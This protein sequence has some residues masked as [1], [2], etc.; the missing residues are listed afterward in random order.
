M[1]PPEEI[2][3]EP[4]MDPMIAAEPAPGSMDFFAPEDPQEAVLPDVLPERIPEAIDYNLKLSEEEAHQLG[5]RVKEEV[6][7]WEAS[8]EQRR[9]N[10]RIWE[11]DFE[12]LEADHEG[13]WENSAAVRAPFTAWA[14]GSHS[15]R[16]NGAIISPKPA[17]S[18]VAKQ[19]AALEAAPVIEEVMQA[20]LEESGWPAFANDMHIELPK[21]GMGLGGVEWEI[22][23]RRQP[24]PHFDGDEAL[25]QQLIETGADPEAALLASL[26][27]GR[28]GK[29]KPSI[30]F[31]DV[32]EK[33][34]NRI[35]MVPF[36]QMILCPPTATHKSQLWGIGEYVRLR[37]LDLQR[38]AESGKYLKDAVEWLLEKYSD[39]PRSSENDGETADVTGLD[40]GADGGSEHALYR[41][42][43][44]VELDWF[45]DLNGDGKPEWYIVGVHLESG[46]LFR[47]QY[48][49]AEHGRSRYV[50]Y[51][52]LRRPGKLLAASLAERMAGLQETATLLLCSVI[53]L[54]DVL[55][56]NSTSFIYDFTTGIK[57]GAWVNG[58]GIHKYVNQVSGVKEMPGTQSIP[59]AINALMGVL[60]M[61]KDWCDLLSATSNTALGKTTDGDKT[62]GE[63]KLAFGSANELFSNYVAWVAEDHA[64]LVDRARWNE[65][66]Y[67][68]NGSVEYRATA[69][70]GDMIEPEPG[71]GKKAGREVWQTGPDGQPVRVP[72]AGP[73]A[74]GKV[75]ARLLKAD[76]DLVPTALGSTPDRE[77]R[78]RRDSFVMESALKHPIIS[79]MRDVLVEL[80]NVVLEDTQMPQRD[81]LMGLVQ[82][83]LQ[84]MEAAEQQ[85]MAMQQMQLLA[86]QAQQA[87]QGALAQQQEQRAG[88][89]QEFQQKHQTRL[90]DQ[91]AVLGIVNAMSKGNGAGKPVGGKK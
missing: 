68:R 74:F 23:Y 63:I 12:L 75:P 52:Y 66:Q 55:K 29:A 79:Q 82:A 61:V 11:R 77:G 20:K 50:V 25:T 3:Q 45:D 30:A 48:N 91:Q 2:P 9:E 1:L 72:V 35:W 69:S 34:G 53:D 85:Q 14:C 22:Q 16:L 49:P 86:G 90:A 24:V 59:V 19:A 41:E 88:A 78:L 6:D 87:Q 76:V 42:Y 13:P 17:F 51:G 43:E 33:D 89:D 37:G 5:R 64:E 31:E 81:R 56:G 58:V 39:A 32:V 62:L 54:T 60:G 36:Q 73:V 84:K 67:A 57:P 27:T 26:K 80:W 40:A 8:V 46:R 47:C 7:R 71:Q 83:N 15:S 65:A 18:A 10:A 38:G 21:T 44:G 70:A 4:G 28:D